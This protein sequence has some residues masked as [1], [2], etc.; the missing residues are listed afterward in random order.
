MKITRNVWA[1]AALLLGGGILFAWLLYNISAVGQVLSF[2]WGLVFPFVLGL[3]LA[4]LLNLPMA[5]IEKHLFRGRGGRAKRPLS[6]GITLVLLL[7]FL[8]IIVFVVIPQLWQT[9]LTLANNMPG[10]IAQTEKLLQPWLDYVPLVEQWLENLDLDWADITGK[11][12][13]LLTSGAGNFFSSAVGVAT[14]IVGGFVSFFVGV[15]FAVY[16]VFGKEHLLAQTK[17]L[18]YAYLP[19]KRYDTVLETGQLVYRTYARFV[20]GQCT[21][22]LIVTLIYLVVL[23]VGGFDY[24]LLISIM[25]GITTL[26]PMI[27]A[28]L[29]C[30]LG[31]FL[32]FFSMGFVRTLV[33]VILFVIIQ[34]FEGNLIYPRVVGSSVGLPPM[35]I[36]VAVM[37]GGGLG[38]LFGMLFFIPLFSVVYTLVR[39]SA[40]KRLAAKGVALPTTSKK[41]PGKKRRKFWG[42]SRENATVPGSEDAPGDATT[43]GDGFAGGDAPTGEST[44][45]DA[46]APEGAPQQGPA[47]DAPENGEAPTGN[48]PAGTPPDGAPP[49]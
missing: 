16:L 3:I 34:Q 31:A 2:A 40:V 30:V 41:A 46:S 38:G 42:K 39:R 20:S 37:V 21:E 49:V 24:P 45:F 27:G 7:G 10:Y 8:A 36:L 43:D 19:Q 1:R 11:I 44:S 23:W 9:A 17:G 25:V 32:L 26:I 14:N 22:A 15:V 35:W 48:T 13:G 28:F 4:F 6:F 5:A 12:S 29:G 33:F 47:D 18:L